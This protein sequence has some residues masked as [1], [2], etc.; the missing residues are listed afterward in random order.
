MS[1]TSKTEQSQNKPQSSSKPK[2]SSL[3]VDP[4]KTISYRQ[5]GSDRKRD[6]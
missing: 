1:N 2:N 6:K 5:D 3:K 4:R